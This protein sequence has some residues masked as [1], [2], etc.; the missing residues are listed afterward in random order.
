[1]PDEHQARDRHVKK[2]T[3]RVRCGADAIIARLAGWVEPRSYR[4][5]YINAVTSFTL[6]QL[7]LLEGP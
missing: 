5:L 1:M 4:Y 3:R 2:I 7:M 6:P